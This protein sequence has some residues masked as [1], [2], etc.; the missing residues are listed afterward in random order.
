MD[1]GKFELTEPNLLPFGLGREYC[2]VRALRVPRVEIEMRRYFD[3][4]TVAAAG[5]ADRGF[6]ERR[7]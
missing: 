4:R 3:N 6:F 5:T 2:A 1:A 7:Q